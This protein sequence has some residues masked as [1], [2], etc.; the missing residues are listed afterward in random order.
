MENP[1]VAWEKVLG[2]YGGQFDPPH[3]GHREVA[4]SVLLDPGLQSLYVLPSGSAPHKSSSTPPA[5]R[6]KM[7]EL[8]FDGIQG[9]KISTY[10]IEKSKGTQSQRSP[11]I[12]FN[13]SRA[14][15]PLLSS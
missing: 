2:L 8:N 12:L 14:I 10:E 15:D 4:E 7:C 11:I 13:T 6:L 5:D 1:F 3:L 9:I